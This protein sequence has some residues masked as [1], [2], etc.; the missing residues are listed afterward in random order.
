MGKKP[1]TT[2]PVLYGQYRPNNAGYDHY[3]TYLMCLCQE[4]T[5]WKTAEKVRFI[6]DSPQ[7]HPGR[8]LAAMK[9]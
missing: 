7:H 9:M 2:L 1:L 5:P 6:L 3:I 4:S 8:T